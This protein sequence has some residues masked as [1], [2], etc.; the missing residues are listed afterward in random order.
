MK[1][2]LDDKLISSLAAVASSI[3][4]GLL[5]NILYDEIFAATYKI[6]N[7]GTTYTII[8]DNEYSVISKIFIVL[9]IFLIVWFFLSILIPT[10]ATGIEMLIHRKTPTFTR[11]QLFALYREC[12][13]QLLKLNESM[14]D[15]DYACENSKL[16]LGELARVV[17]KLYAKFCSTKILEQRVVRSSFR[18][19]STI[20]DFENRISF[21]EY[22]KIIC[23]ASRILGK[24][25]PQNLDI[26]K[27]ITNELDIMYINDWRKISSRINELKCALQ[28][29]KSNRP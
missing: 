21:Y 1:I 26:E 2:K 16:Y 27:S 17:N 15:C 28:N 20:D 22:E 13:E 5:T 23:V 29:S 12:K 24:L 14:S 25:Q 4:T 3:L 7:E 6:V 18:T 9:F 11:L 10:V 8:E 19:G